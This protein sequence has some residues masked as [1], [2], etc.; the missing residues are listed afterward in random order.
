MTTTADAQTSLTAFPPGTT[1]YEMLGVG[2]AVTDP[3]LKVAYRRA[4]LL[5]H[6]DRHREDDRPLAEQIFK[7][8]TAAYRTLSNPDQ[9]RRYD[10]ALRGGQEFR[11]SGGAEGVASLETILAEI[12]EYECIFSRDQLARLDP[13]IGRL[14]LEN[15]IEDLREDVVAVYALKQAPPN[16]PYQGTFKGGAVVLTNIR[17][18]M[19]FATEWQETSGN[20]RTTYKALSMPGAAWPMVTELRITDRCRLHRDVLVELQQSDRTVAFQATQ[21]NLA[22]LLLIGNLWGVPCTVSEDDARRSD[23]AFA[24]IRPWKIAGVSTLALLIVAALGGLFFGS[25]FLGTPLSL[26]NWASREG[27]AQA[28]VLLASG[29]ASLRLSRWIAAYRRN[30]LPQLI[31]DASAPP[32]AAGLGVAPISSGCP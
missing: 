28:V 25:G 7:D 9:R 23:L 24:L 21:E 11:E 3:E 13:A 2:S 32:V 10:Q 20:V 16:T 14:V 26:L 30:D 22:E 19:P 8:I 29:T 27:V 15:L 12:D 31:R 6:P 5:Y 4:A 18:L 17:V 1:K